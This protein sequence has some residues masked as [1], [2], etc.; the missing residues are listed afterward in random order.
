MYMD[1]VKVFVKKWKSSENLIQTIKIYSYD[2]KMEVDIKMCNCDKF[3]W[4]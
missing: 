1:D 2:I 3:N 4:L